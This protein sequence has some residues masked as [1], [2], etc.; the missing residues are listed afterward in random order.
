MT[1]DG[2]LETSVV[3]IV[4]NRPA[5]TRAVFERIAR[6]R[7]KRLLI[8]ADGPRKS[9]PGEAQ[10]CDEVRKIATEVNWPC[11]V[12]VN[13]SAENLGCRNRI[14]SGLNWAF[15]QVEEAIILEDDILPDESFFRFCEEML[16]RYRGDSRISM[17][18]GFN[19]VQD[20]LASEYSYFFSQWSHIWGWATWRG[21]WARYDRLLRDWPEI[22]RSA[23]LAEV[24][25]RQRNREYWERVFDEMHG[26]AGIDTWDHQWFY[27]NLIHRSLSIVPRGNLVTNMGFG[28]DATHSTDEASDPKLEIRPMQ[29]PL[30][31]PPTFIPL[32]G[33]DRLDQDLCRCMLPSV[34]QR[35][36]GKARRLTRRFTKP[37]S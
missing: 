6:V 29:F 32:L 13:A 14:I 27:T 24:F 7:P 28:G 31:H 18:T 12:Q 8:V 9:R 25:G 22:K 15:Q 17:I 33:M 1:T 23:V 3:F 21:A 35:I 34:S 2:G 20:Q 19:I 10:R 26:G 37:G 36:L 11:E 16:T 30:I 5:M 4:F